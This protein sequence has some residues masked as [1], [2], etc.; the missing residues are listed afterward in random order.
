[1]HMKKETR[2]SLYRVISVCVK[3]IIPKL[4]FLLKLH[5]FGRLFQFKGERDEFFLVSI[6]SHFF[7]FSYELHTFSLHSLVTHF[8]FR[9]QK[10]RHLHHLQSHKDYILNICL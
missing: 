4:L 10:T 8:L 6:K 7:Q 5:R 3:V 1:M 2:I 9:L